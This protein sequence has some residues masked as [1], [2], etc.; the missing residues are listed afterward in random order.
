MLDSSRSR[1]GLAAA[2]I[3]AFAF[4]VN[5]VAAK[6][7]ATL[8]VSAPLIVF[9]RLLAMLAVVVVAIIVTRGSIKT[10]RDSIPAM[11]VL[12]VTN[13]GM[14]LAYLSSVAFIPV[15]VAAVIFYTYPILIVLAGPM[16]TGRSLQPRELIVSFIAFAGI[17]LVVGPSF[18]ALDPRGLALALL[19]SAITACQF[20]AANRV[21]GESTT[22]KLFWGTL[23]ALPIAGAVLAATTGFAGPQ[24]LTL[25]PTPVAITIVGYVIG[26][27]GLIVSL[28][29]L[30]AA[31]AGLVF[32]LEPVISALVSAAWLDERLTSVQYAGGA[33]VICAVIA[34][35]FAPTRAL[36]PA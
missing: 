1:A 12:I 20:F 34:T 36:K 13:A 14:G 32:C 22:A 35:T 5:T 3:A 33:L 4:G 7:S 15:T 10:T 9:Y 31:V 27:V 21:A 18:G 16:A 6:A 25:A 26:S 17:I 24:A 30:N 28:S 29:R 11:I 19:G 23:G 8:G 2:I